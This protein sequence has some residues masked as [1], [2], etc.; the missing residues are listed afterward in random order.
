M[1]HLNYGAV[2][3]ENVYL[4][5]GASYGVVNCRHGSE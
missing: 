4:S 3:F 1:V 2:F 5:V